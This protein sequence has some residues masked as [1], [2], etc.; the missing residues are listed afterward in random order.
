MLEYTE[1]FN[2]FMEAAE[3]LKGNRHLT[4]GDKKRILDVAKNFTEVRDSTKIVDPFD[5]TKIFD[6]IAVSETLQVLGIEPK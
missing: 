3:E 6:S 5:D 2:K 4:D 1:A